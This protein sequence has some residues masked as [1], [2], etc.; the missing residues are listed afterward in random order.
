MD[1]SK[2]CKKYPKIMRPLLCITL[3]TGVVSLIILIA[4]II[5]YFEDIISA[6]KEVIDYIKKGN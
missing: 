1:L 6:H 3:F 2:L 4:I 5:E